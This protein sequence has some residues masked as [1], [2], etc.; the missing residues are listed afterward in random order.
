MMT[1]ILTLTALLQNGVYAQESQPTLVFPF[2]E[3]EQWYVY[4]GYNSGTHAGTYAYSF[5]L[6][7][8]NEATEGRDVISPVTGTVAWGGVNTTACDGTVAI[9]TTEAGLGPEGQV[10]YWY[11]QL[12]HMKVNS[13]VVTNG[14]AVTLGQTL[15]G[16]ASN[17]LCGEYTIPHIHL[18]IYKGELSDSRT[19]YREAVPFANL[20]GFGWP[21]NGSVNQYRTTSVWRGMAAGDVGTIPTPVPV[22]TVTPIP[23]PTATPIP[24]ATST[25]DPTANDHNPPTGGIVDAPAVVNHTLLVKAQVDD[26]SGVAR[27]QL[28]IWPTGGGQSNVDLSNTG[29]NVWETTINVDQYANGTVL[30]YFLYV[31]DASINHNPVQLTGV[32]TVVVTKDNTPPTGN[33]LSAPSVVDSSLQVTANIEDPSGVLAVT[34]YTGIGSFDMV[35]SG[36]SNTWESTIDTSNQPSG[37]TFSY[38]IHASDVWGNSV[39]VTGATNVTVNHDTTPPTG[40]YITAP[41]VAGRSLDISAHLEDPSGVAGATLY[42][43]IGTFEMAKEGTSET[44]S[45]TVETGHLALGTTFN[46]N[47]HAKD[48][49]GNS[50]QV[51]GNQP[52]TVDDREPPTGYLVNVNPN[53]YNNMVLQADFDPDLSGVAWVHAIYKV[54]NGGWQTRSMSNLHTN[55]WEANIDIRYAPHGTHIEYYIFAGDFAGNQ[56]QT[57]GVQPVDVACPGVSLTTWCAEYYNNT[58]LSGTPAYSQGEGGTYIER[59]YGA[60]EPEGGR[61]GLGKDNFSIR[62]SKVVDFGTNYFHFSTTSDDGVRVFLDNTVVI[63]EW[64]PGANLNYT[65]IRFVPA[66]KHLVLLEYVEYGGLAH[67]KFT[68]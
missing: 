54:G 13:I 63:G 36:S 17:A 62:W 29:S 46:Y 34:L 23:V 7:E 43:G 47:I 45:V 16:K 28:T 50:V 51:T 38:N 2:R 11:V 56:A 58:T 18:S 55:H 61:G 39:Q 9:R 44:W 6:T 24:T 42:S 53:P 1:V 60:Y 31:W 27:V 37:S 3:G 15:I 21:S 19:N 41:S 30:N 67:V 66:G 14:S 68:W 8:L 48:F 49:K 52:V 64:H 26:A 35:R 59:N 40:Y 32:N 22:A 12:A 33:Y 10:L 4:Q 25:P 57:T 20:E 5:D 65:A